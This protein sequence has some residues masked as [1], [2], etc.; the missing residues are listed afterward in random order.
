MLKFLK[1]IL[2]T[3]HKVFA[4]VN[5]NLPQQMKVEPDGNQELIGSAALQ[6]IPYDEQFGTALGAG[7]RVIVFGDW[8]RVFG[9]SEDDGSFPMHLYQFE[10][11]P[12]KDIYR[13]EFL[14]LLNVDFA[15]QDTNSCLTSLSAYFNLL[16]I[17]PCGTVLEGK[18]GLLH[19]GVWDMNKKGVNALAVA[20]IS[21]I[22]TAATDVGFLSKTNAM[23][24]LKHLS[25]Y[26]RLHFNDWNTFAENFLNGEDHVGLTNNIG[27]SYLKRYAGYLREKKGSPWKN[28]HWKV[29][30]T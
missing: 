9:S 16:G 29:Q 23:P 21:H 18:N 27:K 24:I 22:T 25:C 4:K 30:E 12:K 17:E 19:G 5:H 6:E 11:Y 10:N 14:T 13:S 20:V 28:I 15:I 1:E 7:F 3:I 2:D 26:V 8:F